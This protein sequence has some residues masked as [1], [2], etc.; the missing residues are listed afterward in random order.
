MNNIAKIITALAAVAFSLAFSSCGNGDY[1]KLL[2]AESAQINAYINRNG[3]KV[4]SSYPADSVWQDGGYYKTKSG[5][6]IHVDDLGDTSD[7]IVPN[8]NIQASYLK[9][10]LD[11]DPEV[12]ADY[13]KDPHEIVY[14]ASSDASTGMLEA[15]GIMRCH[16]AKATFILPSRIANSVDMNAVTPYLYEMTIKLA[17]K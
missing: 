2:D 16:G 10:T 17:N 6:Y 9:K 14:G 8:M 5:I 13:T 3:I 1:E 15:I 11:V 4:I 7:T 12:V